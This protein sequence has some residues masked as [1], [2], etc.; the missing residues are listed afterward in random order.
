MIFQPKIVHEVTGYYKFA[1]FPCKQSFIQS[2]LTSLRTRCYDPAGVG[3]CLFNGLLTF[4]YKHR[5]RIFLFGQKFRALPQRLVRRK[6]RP[7]NPKFNTP[8]ITHG[9]LPIGPGD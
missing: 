2:L 6:I 3:C 4:P 8:H 1:I 5:L 9:L 7:L